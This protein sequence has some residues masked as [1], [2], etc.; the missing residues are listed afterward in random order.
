[1]ALIPSRL[2]KFIAFE[3]QEA[4]TVL[5]SERDGHRHFPIQIGSIEAI[6]LAQRIDDRPPMG[7]PATHDLLLNSATALG[8]KLRE[9]RITDLKS[10]TFFAEL[11]FETND[12]EVVVDSRPSDALVIA[13]QERVDLMVEE[14][15]FAAANR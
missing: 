7:R 12:G 1:M 9:I 4:H 2:A 5:I 6:A 14:S 8:G 11:V 3:H 15:V 10:G 13:A